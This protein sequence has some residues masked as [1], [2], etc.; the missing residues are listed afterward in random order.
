MARIAAL[1]GEGEPLPALTEQAA[2]VGCE[3]SE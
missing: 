1:H 2:L 3:V